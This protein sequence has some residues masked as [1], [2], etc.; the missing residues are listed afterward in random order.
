LL[1]LVSVAGVAVAS[2][3]DGETVFTDAQY[4]AVTICPALLAPDSLVQRIA[5]D[6]D[7]IREQW[8]AVGNIHF[9]RCSYDVPGAASVRLTPDARAAFLAGEHEQLNALHAQ[10]GVPEVEEG[11]YGYLH[12][13][14]ALPY[15]PYVLPDLYHPIDGV[16]SASYLNG[17]YGDGD[18]IEIRS[19]GAYLF[20]RAWGYDCPAGCEFAHVWIFAVTNGQVELVDEYGDDVDP[21]LRTTWGS[22]KAAFR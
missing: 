6:L 11:L 5:S 22:I 3:A 9:N 4:L 16:I 8:P 15:N 19:D 13:Y 12:L 21:V 17:C 18:N 2:P 7:V 14:F 1:A 10:I 20:T